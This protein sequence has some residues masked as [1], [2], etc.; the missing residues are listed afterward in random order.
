MPSLDKNNRI[1][2]SEHGPQDEQSAKNLQDMEQVQK[3]EGVKP[4]KKERYKPNWK[5]PRTPANERDAAERARDFEAVD[6]G[7]SIE[8]AILEANR[9]LDCKRPTCVPGC[10]VGINIPKFIRHIRE[11]D[12]DSA[13]ETIKEDNLL[14]SI[15][16][17]VC[18]Q[19]R[20]CEGHCVL[21][22]KSEPVAIGQLER[23]V[24]D[25]AGEIGFTTGCAL[26]NGMRVAVIGSG[27]AGLACA[28]ELS[29]LGYGVTIFEA[30]SKGGGVLSYGI[31][32]FRLPKEVVKRELDTLCDIDVEFEFDS[33]VGRI[34]DAD[35]LFEKG[36]DA[37]FISTG[38]GLPVFLGLPGE[39]LSGVFCANEYLTRVN[40]MKGYKFPEYDTPVH[41]G[42]KV[43]V[44]GAGNVAMDAARTAKRMG[45][46]E[47]T[48]VYRR[49]EAEMPA[50]KA[51]LNHA[52]EEGV[53]IMELT[54]PVEFL[55]NDKKFVRGMVCQ[56]MKLGEP[57]ASGRRRPEPIEG[58][59]F[60]MECDMVVT[61]LGTRANPFV[62]YIDPTLQL[63]RKGYIVCDDEGKTTRDRVWAG[64]DIVTGAATVILAMGA[65]KRA[66]RSI[67]AEL[68][69]EAK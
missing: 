13:I 28:G 32:E 34:T 33:V 27:P 29:R 2:G 50:R 22:G 14:P 3:T 55:G 8:D 54:A 69:G 7:F 24:G 21:N 23:F 52:K 43:A 66:A 58:E 9:C 56:R 68:K 1:E 38:A 31:P 41:K 64:G 44:I 11:R 15:C 37:I 60:E 59:T 6:L 39:H 65:G 18:P 40:F 19:E 30:M 12:F 67:H 17:R 16:G 45:A 51:E 25:L 10:P 47:V 36:F 26:P 20:Q 62:P 46:S 49:T 42:D 63:N 4:E 48:L 57:D 53:K 35:E 61:A 5:S